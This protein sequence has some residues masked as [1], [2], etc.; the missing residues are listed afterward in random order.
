LCNHD[1]RNKLGTRLVGL[2]KLPFKGLLKKMG[3][4][5]SCSCGPLKIKGYRYDGKD[6]PWAQMMQDERL[7]N[8][9]GGSGGHVVSFP[10]CRLWAEVFHV[11][12]SSSG[13]VKWTQVSEDLVPVNISCSQDA[14]GVRFHVTAYNSQVEKILDV[15]LSHPG[16]RIGQASECFVYW[17]DDRRNDTWGLNFTSPIDAKQFRECC[18]FSKSSARYLYKNGLRLGSKSSPASP[19]KQEPQCTCLVSEKQQAKLRSMQNRGEYQ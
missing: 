14:T 17:K 5:L 3:N 8:T 4:K 12:T 6:Q 2:E 13:T 9:A 10:I 18:D 16:T 1:V 11:T 19:T 15:I 7:A